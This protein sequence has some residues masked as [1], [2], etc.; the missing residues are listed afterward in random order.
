ME[1]LTMFDI[2]VPDKKEKKI[3]GHPARTHIPGHPRHD[4]EILAFSYGGGVQST[5][6]LVLAAQGKIDYRLFLFANVGEDSENPA[7][8]EYI[9]NHAEPF[10]EENGIKLRWVQ[11]TIGRDKEKRPDTLMGRIERSGRSLP[12]PVRMSNGAPGRRACT[13]DHKILPIDK[14]LRRYGATKENPAV[15]GLGISLDEMQRAR[16]HSGLDTQIIEYPLLDLRISRADCYDIIASAGL[17]VPPKSSCYFCPFHSLGEWHRLKREQPDL[18]DKSV[19]LES[20]LNDRRAR[21][22]KDQIYFT[23]NCIPLANAIGDQM[24]FGGDDFDSCESGY[25]MT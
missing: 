9:R 5:A 25:C 8:I 6:A 20:K 2:N 10:A 19:A 18:F 15:V 24:V 7:T 3:T 12:L 11:K 21:F 13:V 22:G 23:S 4:K 17:P 16:S 14:M 1:Q